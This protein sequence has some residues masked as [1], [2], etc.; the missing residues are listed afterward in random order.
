MQAILNQITEARRIL[1]TGNF[2]AARAAIIKA[3]D[4]AAEV[5]VTRFIGPDIQAVRTDIGRAER[6]FKPLLPRLP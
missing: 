6:G 1:S 4:M 2:S 5:K 3:E